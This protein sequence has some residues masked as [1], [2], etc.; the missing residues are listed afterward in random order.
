MV[1]ARDEAATYGEMSMA[2]L[3]RLPDLMEQKLTKTGYTRG[4]TTKEIFQNRVTRNN[5]VIIDHEYWEA[6]RTPDDGTAEYE[7]GFLVVVQPHWYFT[8][9]DVD[10]LLASEGLE[11]GRNALLLFRRRSDWDAFV[12]ASGVL[13][14][15]KPFTV[16]T[17]R[18]D[19]LGGTYFARVHGTVSA[20]GDQ[21]VTG[22]NSSGQRGAGIRVYE[23]ASSSTIR[24]TRLQ[25]EALVWLCHDSVEAMVQGGMD[26]EAA[27]VRRA[28]QL[29]SAEAEN[30]LDLTRLEQ[31]RL[32]NEE[33][34]TICPLCKV[35]ISAADFMRRGS[36]AAG[37]E[38]Y[39]LTITELSLFHVEE[40]RVGRL[41]HKPYNLGWGH[42]FCN[43]VVKDAGIVPT[44]RW[45]R[46]VL[47]HQGS[48]DLSEEEESIEEA[49]EG[50]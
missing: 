22:F 9:A 40:L 46:E 38:V 35:R 18:T 16:A 50:G 24:R 11:L 2:T 33:H 42:H 27:E 37:R 13:P 44:L 32:V 6:C 17:S 30:L 43:V 45:M 36:Q 20:S 3:P 10:E 21:V 12:P 48:E 34:V 49:V 5:T 26:H 4:A 39:D 41:Q 7:N 31:T 19:P 15:G 1:H 14:S 25:L 28:S 47:D 29:A 8:T 23:Y